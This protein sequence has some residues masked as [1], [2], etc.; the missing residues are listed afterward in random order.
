MM[1]PHRRIFP[2]PPHASTPTA[3]LPEAKAARNK[4]TYFPF[5]GGSDVNASGKVFA[6]MEGV[7]SIATL[8]SRWRFRYA[9]DTPPVPLAKI[10]LRPRDPLMMTA[11]PRNPQ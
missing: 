7:F 4:Y 5:G 6:W 2:Q 9:A 1:S 3:S 11:E 10:T 8:A